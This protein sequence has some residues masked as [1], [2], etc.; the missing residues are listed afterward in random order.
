MSYNFYELKD[1]PENKF[2]YSVAPTDNKVPGGMIKD[3]ERSDVNQYHYEYRNFKKETCFWVKRG[4]K[5]GKKLFTPMSYD[6]DKASWV[7]KAWTK[8]RPLFGEHVLTDK[9][10]IVVEGEKAKLEGD[11]LFQDYDVVTWSGGANQVHQTNFEAL[12]DR[13][14][15]LWADNDAPGIKAMHEVALALIDNNLTEN[16]S[17]ITPRVELEEGWDIADPLPTK[18]LEIGITKEGL[19]KG[20]SEYIPDSKIIKQIKTEQEQRR[21]KEKAAQLSKTYC[22]VMSNDMFNKI[23]SQEFYQKQQ[24]NNFWKHEVKEGSLTDLL[25]KN[26]EFARAETFMTHAAYPPGLNFI[27]RPGI[28]PLVQ[29][30]TIL[31]IYTPNYIIAKKGDV[32]FINQYFVWLLG[33]KKWKII[34]EWIAYHL[35]HPGDKIKWSLVLVSVIEGTG[36]GM[37]ARIISKIL[38]IENVNEN[39][40]YKHL[41]NTHNTLLVG[42]QVLVL[43]EVSLGDFKGK[44]EGTNTLKN[45]VADD[46]YTCN[47]KGKPMVKL[48]NLTNI[49]LYSNDERVVGV[50]NGVRRYFFCNIDK[51]E[52]DIIIKSDEGFYDKAWKFID[53]DDGAAALLYYFK[54]EVKIKDISQ[55]KKRAPQTEDLKILIEQSKHPVQKKLEA[56]LKGTAKRIRIFTEDW[57][58]LMSFDELNE[59][60]NTHD[61]HGDRYDWGSYGDDALLK[62]LSSNCLRWNNKETTRQIEIRNTWHRYYILED[63]GLLVGKSYKDMTPKEIKIMS[64]HWHNIK[65]DIDKEHIEFIKA[66]QLYPE[67]KANILNL[68]KSYAKPVNKSASYPNRGD[69]IDLMVNQEPE[70]LFRKIIVEKDEALNK[71]LPTHKSAVEDFD[72]MKKTHMIISRGSRSN[73]QIFE[74]YVLTK[75]SNFATPVRRPKK[76]LDL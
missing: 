8:D 47:F 50:S 52:D 38:G 49:I 28:I 1:K 60:L 26:K 51:T 57:S 70:D 12:M 3:Q 48:P 18:M 5:N 72:G 25:L 59:I 45:F 69:G 55:F 44:A 66:E 20:K 36:K 11:K 61:N 32:S 42:C 43:N 71:A 9:P 39:A 13:E 54:H 31:N 76:I 6:T 46:Y 74:D 29:R 35:L 7:A 40:N 73:K 23:G 30:G 10:V 27:P 4:I 2:N 58:G 16:I 75:S 68:L 14:V 17:M 34:E 67:L 22:Y 24:L 62:F 63:K 33:E 19:L 37:L 15:I 21:S 53:S 64:L 65:Q 41:T 56:D